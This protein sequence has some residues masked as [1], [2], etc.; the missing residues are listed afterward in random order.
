LNMST[1]GEF[2]VLVRHS[3]ERL[4]Q[5]CPPAHAALRHRLRDHC[6]WITI[7]GEQFSLAPVGRSLRLSPALPQATVELQTSRR[8]L[9]EVL[10]GSLP[11][12]DAVLQGR[13]FLRGTAQALI[14]FH[15][16]LVIYMR[17]AVRCP[18][19]PELLPILRQQAT[20]LLG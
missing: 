15:E 9:L 1:P 3:L 7:D 10:E 16:A 20:L 6:L 18:S 8:T 11:L 14:E 12:L 19:L 2:M 13:L 5:E 17:G 4:E